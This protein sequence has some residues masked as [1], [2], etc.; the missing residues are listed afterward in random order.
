MS[1]KVIWSKDASLDLVDIVSY[2]KIDSGKGIAKEI[3]TRIKSEVDKIV[4]F[5]KAGII[6]PELADIGITDIYQIIVSPWKVYYKVIEDKILVLSVIDG[7]RNLEE[8]LYKK[9]ISG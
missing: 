9:I 4:D 6:V 7:R 8:I 2:I 1:S 5:P 3:Y